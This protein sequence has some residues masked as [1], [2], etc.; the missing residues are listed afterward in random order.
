MLSAL[1]PNED[2][3]DRVSFSFMVLS[4]CIFSLKYLVFYIFLK[5]LKVALV[6]RKCILQVHSA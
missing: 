3:Y 2:N 6:L 4:I 5:F 1:Q